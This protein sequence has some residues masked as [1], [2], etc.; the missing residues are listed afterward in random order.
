[1]ESGGT[2]HLGARVRPQGCDE[3]LPKRRRGL[4]ENGT[5]IAVREHGSNA[6]E[7]GALQ[8]SIIGF[9]FFNRVA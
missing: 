8:W 2:I 7:R 1:M 3:S 5:F 4:G 6:A 9:A